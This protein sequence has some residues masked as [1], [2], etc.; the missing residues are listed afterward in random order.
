MFIIVSN[1][2]W[3]V[4]VSRVSIVSKEVM[5]PRGSDFFVS[6]VAAVAVCFSL[7]AVA[8]NLLIQDIMSQSLIS[9]DS[10]LA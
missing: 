4:R 6:F 1:E 3:S 7:S 5:I 8:S 10:K 9:S 2:C